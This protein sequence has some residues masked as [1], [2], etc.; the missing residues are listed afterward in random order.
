MVYLC[1]I[2]PCLFIGAIC[3][4]KILQL[5][6]Q[7]AVAVENL[8]DHGEALSGTFVNTGSGPFHCLKECALISHSAVDEQGQ[9]HVEKIALD[10][11]RAAEIGCGNAHFTG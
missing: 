5:P 8:F 7:I 11:R 6:A 3:L 1:D 9:G 2:L 10:S 4:F